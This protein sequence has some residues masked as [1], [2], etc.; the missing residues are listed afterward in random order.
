MSRNMLVALVASCTTAVF[1]P[2]TEPAF[3]Q[4]TVTAGGQSCIVTNRVIEKKGYYDS[5]R[6]EL[7]NRCS[8]PVSA[9]VCIV[10]VYQQDTRQPCDP[11]FGGFSGMK[12]APGQKTSSGVSSS[13]QAVV[14]VRECPAG[15]RLG[16]GN[17]SGFPCIK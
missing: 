9:Y 11:R 1:S 16:S 5:S 7:T 12:W 17:V 4:A 2:V 8:Q 6:V 15:Y 10:A 13:A 3:A 14:V